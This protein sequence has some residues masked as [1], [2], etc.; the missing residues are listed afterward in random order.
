MR[1]LSRYYKNKKILITG[2]TGF[3]GSWLSSLLNLIGSNVYGVSLNSEKNSH[4]ENLKLDKKIKSKLLDIR[5]SKKLNKHLELIKPDIVFHLAAQS[6]VKSSYINPI[7]TWTTNV[8]GTL[9]V[10]ESVKRLNKKCII[11][12]ITSDKCYL[13]KEKQ[14]G[15][16]ESDELGGYDP[17][18][19]SKASAEHVFFSEYHSYLKFNKKIRIAS[20]RGGNV[21]GGGDWSKNRIIPDFI[22]S[23]IK[24]D[25]LKVRN[26]HSTRPW[27]HVLEP[28]IGYLKLAYKLDKNISLNGKAFNFGS[29]SKSRK[30]VKDILLEMNKKMISGKWK[31]SKIDKNIIETKNLNIDSKYAKKNL[32]WGAN[33]TFEKRIKLTAD[34]Y[35]AYIKNKKIITL[36]QI[37]DFLR[38]YK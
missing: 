28:L 32:G 19:A 20:A 27:V 30:S 36:N 22:K 26:P 29:N 18:S 13:N 35:H 25:F 5:N 33:L 4:Y 31:F 9:N 10:I 12:I 15:Y 14:S 38:N 3:K 2:H 34:W 37:R 23:I 8:I 11:I 16:K 7:E 24:K 17:Y 21:V 1:L 6:L